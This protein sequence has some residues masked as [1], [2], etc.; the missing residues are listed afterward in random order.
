MRRADLF[1]GLGLLVFAGLY[2]RESFAI[3]VGFAAD[4]LGPRFFPRMLAIALATCALALIRRSVAGRSDPGP[5]K[6]VRLAVLAGAAVLTTVYA[7]LLG[8]LGYVIAT[9]LY[10]SALIVLLGHRDLKS[11][12][13]LTVGGTAVLYLV[14]VRALHVLVPMGPL[15][16]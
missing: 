12:L 9:P 8:P 4:R 1:I 16:R 13:A 10:L 3:T 15:G 6:P 14:F 5:L 7:L 11:L 2:F